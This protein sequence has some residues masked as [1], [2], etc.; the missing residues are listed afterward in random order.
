[1]SEEVI[2]A[3]Q[4]IITKAS[5][6][7]TIHDELGR[8]IKIKQPN[9][10]AETQLIEL[11]GKSAENST[12]LNYYAP[13]I[14]VISLDGYPFSIGTTRREMDAALARLD[15]VGIMAVMKGVAEHFSDN[16]LGNELEVKSKVKK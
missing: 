2:S 13:M 3:S 10:I 16:N 8:E 11:L 12:L 15:R 4:E 6:V 7:V 1:M 9:I 5:R 14:Y